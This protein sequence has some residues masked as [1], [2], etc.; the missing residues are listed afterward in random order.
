MTEIKPSLQNSL[1]P[2]I[3]NILMNKTQ[4][5]T[6]PS[7]N[8]NHSYLSLLDSSVISSKK[9][10]VNSSPYDIYGS[11]QLKERPTNNIQVNKPQTKST[12]NSTSF[13]DIRNGSLMMLGDSGSDVTNLQKKLTSVG[14]KV[15]ATGY[16]GNTTKT[17]VKEFQRKNGLEDDGIVG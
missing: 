9:P 12:N 15:Q 6:Q 5:T 3:Y 14:L 7:Q 10:V 16:F 1:N 2:A 13:E 11:L 8:M 4:A 17:L